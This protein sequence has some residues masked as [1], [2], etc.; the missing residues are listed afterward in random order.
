MNDTVMIYKI[1]SFDGN[2]DYM[3]FVIAMERG[4]Q[5]SIL[6]S[7]DNIHNDGYTDFYDGYVMAV[8]E[9]NPD[10]QIEEISVSIESYKDIEKYKR[11]L[12]MAGNICEFRDE[13]E[14][15]KKY[16]EYL[17]NHK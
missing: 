15:E 16:Q 12:E 3:P 1:E 9:F 6:L 13:I 2:G 17:K 8:K 7:G 14:H 10:T 5:I 4:K 11:F